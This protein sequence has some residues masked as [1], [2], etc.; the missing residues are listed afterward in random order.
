MHR[1]PGTQLRCATE[2]YAAQALDEDVALPAEPLVF[3]RSSNALIG[4]GGADRSPGRRSKSTPTASYALVIGQ[5][6][7]SH[8]TTRH[9]CW[10]ATWPRST[11]T[12]GISSSLTISGFGGRASTRSARFIRRWTRCRAMSLHSRSDR[13][14]RDRVPKR[15]H[16]ES[17]VGIATLVARS[18]GVLTLERGDVIL[19]WPDVL[20]ISAI[21][22]SRSRP[23]TSSRLHPRVRGHF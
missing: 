7:R 6:V 21:P 19:S 4:T 23:A 22:Q 11:S 3:A 20:A 2:S 15:H 16:R 8:L 1:L 13:S 9:R 14:E 17:D 12:H 5:R 10:P 18:T